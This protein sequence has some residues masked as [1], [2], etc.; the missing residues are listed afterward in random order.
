MSEQGVGI[1]ARA[2]NLRADY[3]ENFP[4]NSFSTYCVKTWRY[5]NIFYFCLKINL[6]K[7]R[8]AGIE[9]RHDD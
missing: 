6:K 9:P 2:E 8:S 4:D 7:T 5:Y 3:Y 1:R